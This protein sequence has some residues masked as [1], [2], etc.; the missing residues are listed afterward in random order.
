M[1]G[2][3]RGHHDLADISRRDGLAGAGPDDFK[4]EVLVDH[5]ALAR[6]RLVSDHAEIGG[7][8]R[9]VGLDAVRADLLLQR[10]WKGRA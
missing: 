7:A 3:E 9:L 4:D 10:G 5:H 6:R 1:I 2:V 8:E